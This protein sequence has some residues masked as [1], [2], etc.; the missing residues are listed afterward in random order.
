MGALRDFLRRYG[1]V[2]TAYAFLACGFWL[3]GMVILPQLLMVEK[4]LLYSDRSVVADISRANAEIDRLFVTKQRLERRIDSLGKAPEGEERAEGARAERGGA[5]PFNPFGTGK[6]AGSDQGEAEQI[7]EAKARLERIGREI[8][9][10]ERFV[11]EARGRAEPRYSLENYLEL[12]SSDANRPIFFKT[13]WAS[14]LVTLVA[15]VICYPVAFYLAKAAPANATALLMLGLVV[16]CWINEILRVF[17]WLIILADHGVLNQLLDDCI[18]MFRWNPGPCELAKHLELVK[19]RCGHVGSPVQGAIQLQWWLTSSQRSRPKVPKAERDRVERPHAHRLVVLGDRDEDPLP[20][21]ELERLERSV[22]GVDEPQVRN[23]FA[24]VDGAF[25][26]KVDAPRRGREHLAGPVRGEGEV[27]GVGEFGHPLAPP[28]RQVRDHH[29]FAEVELRLEEDP[30]S[31]GAVAAAVKRWAEFSTEH[32]ACDRMRRRRPRV[33]VE[34]PADDLRDQVRGCVDD[35][36]VGRPPPP[37][38]RL[39]T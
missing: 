7:E 19:R 34:R 4:S 13:I 27:G 38:E 33:R 9:E 35:V 6:P 20:V 30:P 16:P 11:E 32:G 3:V 25:F 21:P 18:R 22:G 24:A 31:A 14:I 36:L 37:R 1:V 2:V 28:T 10:K 17:S 39:A 8:A 23:T 5:A 12:F 26:L 15:L 29:L